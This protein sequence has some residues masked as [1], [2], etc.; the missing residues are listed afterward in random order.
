ML[1]ARKIAEHLQKPVFEV[2]EWPNSELEFWAA[3][4]SIDQNKD[5]P[6]IPKQQT[7]TAAQIELMK[8]VLSI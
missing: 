6:I 5:K 7:D 8:K 4:F 3:S 2:M 1:L